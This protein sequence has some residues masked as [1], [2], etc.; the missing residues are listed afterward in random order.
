MVISRGAMVKWLLAGSNGEMVISMGEM[1]KW[2]LA[3]E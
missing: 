1:V 3:G 2:L